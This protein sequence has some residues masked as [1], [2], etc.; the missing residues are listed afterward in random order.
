MRSQCPLL[1]KTEGFKSILLFKIED[2]NKPCMIIKIALRSLMMTLYGQYIKYLVYQQSSNFFEFE[3]YLAHS[4]YQLP[5]N[6]EPP[7]L[8]YKYSSIADKAPNPITK[9]TLFFGSAT[10]DLFYLVPQGIVHVAW[11]RRYRD[12][13]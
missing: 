8:Y 13:S 7:E 6:L 3:K 4:E 10:V 1:V 11:F 9:I 2:F 5:V 12:K